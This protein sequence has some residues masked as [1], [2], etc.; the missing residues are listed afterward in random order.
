MLISIG[1]ELTHAI[2]ISLEIFVRDS[3][4]QIGYI[5]ALRQCVQ[6]VVF[7]CVGV[8]DIQINAFMFSFNL[9]SSI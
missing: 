9:I 5:I 4:G 8:Q 3:I 2:A 6:E 7:T 1:L